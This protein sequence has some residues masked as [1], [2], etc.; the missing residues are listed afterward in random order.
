MGVASK[1]PSLIELKKPLVSLEKSGFG[2]KTTKPR[3]LG[4]RGFVSFMLFLKDTQSGRP[5][6]YYYQ[7]PYDVN[8]QD[9]AAGQIFKKHNFI[10][11]IKLALLFSK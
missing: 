10:P 1:K 11:F 7:Y 5:P 9:I 8:Y 2:A 4:A 3:V 6:E